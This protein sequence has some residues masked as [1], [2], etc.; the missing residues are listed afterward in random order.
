M[1]ATMPNRTYTQDP[2]R[3]PARVVRPL[4]RRGRTEADWLRSRRDRADLAVFPEFR[5]PP[6]GGGNELLDAIRGDLERWGPRAGPTIRARE[7][8]CSA[9][10]IGITIRRAFA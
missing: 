5:P 6:Y 10:S 7:S 8:T 2:V 1:R 9:G 4:D 3:H